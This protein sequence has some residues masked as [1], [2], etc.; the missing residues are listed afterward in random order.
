MSSHGISLVEAEARGVLGEY[1]HQLSFPAEEEFAIIYGP[2]GVGK[3]K[4]LEIIHAMSRLDGRT[5]SRLPFREAELRFSDATTL[6]VSSADE[7]DTDSSEK[8]QRTRNLR[9]E[10]RRGVED[11]EVWFYRGDSFEDWLAENTSW[12]Q[13]D[14]FLWEDLHDGELCSLEELQHR[15]SKTEGAG[16]SYPAVFRG[17][18]RSI[19]SYLIE[20]QR[21][22]IEN[23]LEPRRGMPIRPGHRRKHSSKIAEHAAKMR[24]L[25]NDAQ[26]HHSTITQQLDRTFPNRVL[27]NTDARSLL[28]S[29]QIRQRYEEQ[30]EF[31]SRLG[32]VASVGLAEPLSLPDR[33]LEN[34]EL[35]LLALYLEDAKKKLAPFEEL[36]KKI[37]LLEEIINTRLLRKKLRVTAKDGLRVQHNESGRSIDL[38]SLSSGE[39]HEII[40]MFDLLFNVPRGAL[41]LIDEPEISLHVVWQLAFIPDV[42]RIAE[43]AGF[44]FVVATHSPQII[45]DA[46]DRA[47]ALGPEEVPFA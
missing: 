21:L 32:R 26:T 22:R 20:T 28:D 46:W 15:F 42:Q 19:N 34:W 3:T 8:R 44:R 9:F 43:L 17:L 24:N 29:A 30:D 10:L 25:V 41:V 12:R 31:R 6:Q 38:D 40:L 45:N 1:D 35:R 27:E 33:E 2:N 4:F 11:S 37:E 16:D 39:Q 47:T 5:L 36:L 18:R 23:A 14:D 7:L 13:F